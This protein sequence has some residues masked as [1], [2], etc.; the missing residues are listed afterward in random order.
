MRGSVRSA[1]AYCLNPSC[2]LHEDGFNARYVTDSWYEPGYAIDEECPVCFDAITSE[3][4]E[5]ENPIEGLLDELHVSYLE[6]DAPWLVPNDMK[7][8]L[9][10]VYQVVFKELRRQA[11]EHWQAKRQRQSEYRMKEAA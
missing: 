9:L 3:P 10:A 1:P 4:V 7:V 6:V 2:E 8:D 11:G 5:Y